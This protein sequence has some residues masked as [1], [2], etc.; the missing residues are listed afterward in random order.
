MLRDGGTVQAEAALSEEFGKTGRTPLHTMK[1]QPTSH[2]EPKA[3]GECSPFK[4]QSTSITLSI[5]RTSGLSPPSLPPLPPHQPLCS[6][7]AL[8]AVAQ[9]IEGRQG[10]GL[11]AW[12][13]GSCM[14]QLSFGDE[15]WF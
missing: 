1:K 7:Q 9:P 6:P 15:E 10:G 11:R 13:G 2:P 8:A 12:E 4:F 14:W 3:R 5:P